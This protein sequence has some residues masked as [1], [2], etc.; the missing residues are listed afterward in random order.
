V[1]ESLSYNIQGYAFRD[2][3]TITRGSSSTLKE[4]DEEEEVTVEDV[5]EE[6]E[7]EEDIP[8]KFCLGYSC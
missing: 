1:T 3:M 2:R 6:E 8:Q 5:V 4:E 7:E